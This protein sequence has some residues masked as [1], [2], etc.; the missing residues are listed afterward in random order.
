VTGKP[1]VLRIQDRRVFERFL[2]L[3]KHRLSVYA[4][5]NIYIWK[6]LFEI[7]W[8]LIDGELC[9]FFKDR[10]SC[11]MYL[12]PLGIKKNPRVIERAFAVMAEHNRDASLSR[13]ENVEE[14]DL[15]RY[16]AWGYESVLKSCD[17]LCK[18]ADM[19]ELR[20]D[21]FKSKRSG[22]N[23]FEKQYQYEYAPFLPGSGK[24]C[25]ALYTRWMHERGNVNQDPVYTGMMRDSLNSLK[26]L[27]GDYGRLHCTGRVVKIDGRIQAFT[28]GF[29]VAEDIFCVLYEIADRA[30]KGLSQFIFRNFCAEFK[31]YAY[32]NIMDDSGLDN[33]KKVKRSYHPAYAVP[34]YIV[35]R[36]KQG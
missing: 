2:G 7:F 14:E 3:E 29:P 10:M 21:R 19:A 12:P 36:K 31:E 24:A 6:G 23:Y 22:V 35:Q 33:L 17:Y 26:I 8:M 13:I 30:I 34:A 16:K 5:P 18:Q 27:L 20:G 9:V 15:A 1:R 28:F 4:F 11:F 32:I 25:I